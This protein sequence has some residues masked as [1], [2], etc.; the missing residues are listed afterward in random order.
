[1]PCSR[2]AASA[3]G[4][5]RSL[6]SACVSLDVVLDAPEVALALVQV[7]EQPGRPWVAVP[8]LAD[9][10]RVE[11]PAVCCELEPRALRC[12]RERARRELEEERD[13]A[14]PHEDERL[15]SRGHAGVRDTGGEDVLPDGVAR[16][17]VE[18]ADAFPLALWPE[19]LEER[20]S[21]GFECLRRPRRSWPL[22][23]ARRSRGRG[24]PARRGR[25]FLSGTRPPVRP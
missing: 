6:I 19:L 21:F 18:Q 5:P 8:R 25:G 17:R 13:V 20:A 3:S 12:G 2:R 23:P 16:T 14:V 15:R 7:E 24:G 9:R 4:S 11:E 22:R 1:M 10:A